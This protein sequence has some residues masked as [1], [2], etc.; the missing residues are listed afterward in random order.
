MKI[1]LPLSVIVSKPRSDK[2]YII[3]LNNYPHWHYI[4]Y[5]NIK[6]AYTDY[7]EDQLKDLTFN[8]RISLI[9][10]YYKKDKRSCDK[11]NVLAVHDKFFCD[12]L[13]HYKCIKDDNDSFIGDIIFKDGG[14]DNVN[15]RV[16]V[17]ILET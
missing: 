6:K 2:R 9:Y 10:T 8:R 14:I 12:S 1:F 4:T 15:P 3:N 16:E 17:E 11:A 7:L 13:V 5:A